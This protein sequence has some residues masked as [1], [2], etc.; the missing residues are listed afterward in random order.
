[1]LW[2]R[3]GAS[4]GFLGVVLGA[5]G[6]HGLEARLEAAGRMETWETAVFYHLVHAV[7]L[8]AVSWRQGEVPRQACRAM[9]AGIVLFSGSLYVLSLTGATWLGAVTPFGGLAFLV[10]WGLLAANGGKMSRGYPVSA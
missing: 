6:A 5:F 4:C 1:M 3:I 9:L 2:S 10:G 7:V 8:F